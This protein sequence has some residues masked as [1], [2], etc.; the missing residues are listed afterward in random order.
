MGQ[1]MKEGTITHWYKKDGESVKNGED[2]YEIEYDKASANVQSTRDGILKIIIAEGQTVAVASVIGMINDPG[3]EA[4][5]PAESNTNTGRASAPAGF[6][7]AGEVKASMQVKRLARQMG[8][9]L[10]QVKPGDPSGRISEQ[11]LERFLK[12]SNEQEEALKDDRVKAS[13][14]AKRQAEENG[15]DLSLVKASDPGGRISKEDV[16]NYLQNN[17]KTDGEVAAVRSE[18]A[19][20]NVVPMSAMRRAIARSMKSSYFSNPV[21]TYS[22]DVDMYELLKLREQLNEELA[23]KG[24][25]A[26]VNDFMIKAAAKA[27]KNKPG[28][29]VSVDG[30]SILLKSDINIGMA[31][32]LENGLVVPV[33]KNA[34]KLKI[35]QVVAE[36]KE[37][38]KKTREGK[39][40][41]ADMSGGTFTITNLGMLGIDMFTPIINMPQSAILGVG[42]A[43]EKPVALNGEVVIRPMMVLSL[44]A[45]HRAID[46]ALAAEFLQEIKKYIHK[47]FLLL[48]D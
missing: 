13:P 44:T 8:V 32:A 45:D 48:Y 16:L 42:R 6:P 19:G 39:L 37:L 9:D 34:D 31:V 41:S 30:E 47:P 33:V 36:T 28:V 24:M 21:V 4:D 2:L 40:T 26:S 23:P 38:I 10:A 22:T 5:N 29:N 7:V 11:D 35:E 25:K 46:G 17:Q 27:L 14:M 1:T 15:V 43:V 20:V 18:T 12:Q 3:E